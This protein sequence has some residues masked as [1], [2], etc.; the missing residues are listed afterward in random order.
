M[1]QFPQMI[2]IRQTFPGPRIDDVPETVRR[3]LRRIDLA[4]AIKPGWRVA[5]AVG[6]RGIACNPA[7]VATVAS[8]LKTLG[9]HP[10]VVSAMGSHGGATAE[11]QKL[12]LEDLG[13]SEKTVGAPIEVTVDV[14]EVGRLENGMPVYMDS[15]AYKADAIIPVNRIKPHMVVG[16]RIGSGVM[17]VMAIGLGKQK[18]C[19]T[20]HRYSFENPAG[21]Y[22]LIEQ[23]ARLFIERMPIVAGIGI[24]DNAYA[25]PARIVAMKAAEIP[26]VEPK[27]FQEAKELLPSLPV[28]DL[29]VL[30]VERMGKNI[31]PAGLDPFIIG[32]RLNGNHTAP[33]RVKRV[34]VLDL[35]EES[36]G[37]AVGLGAADLIAQRLL[38][39][40][41]RHATYMNCISGSALENA[42]I[43]VTLSTDRDVL[44]TAL[45]TIGAVEPQDARVIRIKSTLEVDT[46]YVSQSLVSEVAGKPRVEVI[47]QPEPLTFD[48]TGNLV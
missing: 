24:I 39:K 40:M 7:V 11:G 16:H 4:S 45:K 48:R 6:S 46:L 3:E 43:P 14:T 36:H 18:G 10:F 29:D 38:D 17:K 21:P 13:I 15:N 23:V 42:K 19:S 28:E 41:D 25:Q 37:N 44:E 32:D 2:K 33:P 30:I 20:I 47:G 26:V 5:I 1:M 9:A 31:S 12:V 27:L 22:E 8:E 35:T 34:A